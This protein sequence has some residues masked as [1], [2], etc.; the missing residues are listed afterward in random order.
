LLKDGKVY[1]DYANAELLHK[2]TLVANDRVEGNGARSN[3]TYAHT[4]EVFDHAGNANEAQKGI[5]E[6]LVLNATRGHV[7]KGNSASLKLARKTEK[8]A[9]RVGGAHTVN[10]IFVVKRSP[11]KYGLTKL[12]RDI[13][14][15]LLVTEVAV[16][17]H[18]RVHLLLL[19]AL[20]GRRGGG[21]V[22]Y[23]VVNTDA[24]G[25]N[26]GDPVRG[27][28]AFNVFKA[29]FASLLGG[30]PV[31]ARAAGAVG[32]IS[33]HCD[34]TYLYVVIKHIF[35]S[36]SVEL[37]FINYAVVGVFEYGGIGV[38]IYGNYRCRAIHAYNMMDGSRNANG[39]VN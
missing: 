5:P 33:S 18:N 34:N 21:V 25:I 38:G 17:Q 8:T 6:L 20:N 27:K 36:L 13:G 31:P 12:A 39:D 37:K 10:V 11:N 32:G 7:R 1:G 29:S 16:Y 2:L 19:E 23:E 35:I 26:K 30:I 15:R 4:L 3:L 24:A 22:K 9:L 14:S 28:A